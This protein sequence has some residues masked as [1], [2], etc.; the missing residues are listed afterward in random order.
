[1]LSL[2]VFEVVRRYSEVQYPDEVPVTSEEAALL[3]INAAAVALR[4]RVQ[5]ESGQQQVAPATIMEVR[6]SVAFHVTSQ[7]AFIYLIFH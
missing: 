5:L 6:S 7:I 2:Q 3:W 1:M 4:E